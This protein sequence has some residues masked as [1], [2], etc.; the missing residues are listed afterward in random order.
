MKQRWAISIAACSVAA[1]AAW[2]ALEKPRPDE[3]PVATLA[4]P[5]PAAARAIEGFFATPVPPV[6]PADDMRYGP[7]ASSQRDLWGYAVAIKA[8][9][10][11]AKVMEA[12]HALAECRSLAVLN[13]QMANFVSGGKSALVGPLT[14]ERQMAYAALTAKCAGYRAAPQAEIASLKRLLTERA[15][16]VAPEQLQASTLTVPTTAQLT[17]MLFSGS[18]SMTA[19]A[20][21]RLA[22]AWALSQGLAEPTDEKRDDMLTAAFL[23]ACDLGTDCS[24]SG[25][26]TQFQ[27]VLNGECERYWQGIQDGSSTERKDR[28]ESFRSLLVQA[29]NKKDLSVIGLS[30]A[31]MVAN[32]SQGN[33][34]TSSN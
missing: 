24:P 28:V 11:P 12:R 27:C 30:E 17:A 9:S 21:P 32:D 31:K 23:A 16:L 13:E 10:D 33:G 20:L 19:Q 25:Y 2:W 4:V 14:P 5:T 26:E 29:I 1:A 18:A 34:P 6:T 15:Q 22:K 7:S 8:S 3:R